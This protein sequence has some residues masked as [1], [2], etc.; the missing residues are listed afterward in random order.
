[1]ELGSSKGYDVGTLTSSVEHGVESKL[2]DSGLHVAR[3]VAM[4]APHESNYCTKLIEMRKRM[5]S[6][7]LSQLRM[8]TGVMR[9]GI[10][11]STRT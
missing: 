8:S 7:G 6:I 5:T 11:D 9:R 4:R 2:P 3:L 10:S 1:M